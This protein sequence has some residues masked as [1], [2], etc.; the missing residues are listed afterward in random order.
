MAV[1]LI[2]DDNDDFRFIFRALLAR[3]GYEVH[4]APNGDVGV[5]MAREVR[6]DAIILDIAMPVMGGLEAAAALKSDP[7]TARIPILALTAQA[8]FP[9]GN[10]ALQASFHA[11]LRKP[12]DLTVFLEIL[13]D[14]LRGPSM[15]IDLLA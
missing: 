5:R 1:I 9:D 10:P 12:I 13:T 11:C 3:H 15:V 2:V 14:C 4:D 6:P 8:P 7:A